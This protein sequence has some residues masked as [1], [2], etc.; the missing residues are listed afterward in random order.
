MMM[1][2]LLL[3]VAVGDNHKRDCDDDDDDVDACI[4]IYTLEDSL[5]LQLMK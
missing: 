2:R 1:I 4:Y 3:P 5:L